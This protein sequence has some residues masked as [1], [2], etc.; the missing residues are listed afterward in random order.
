METYPWN[1]SMQVP[2][3][4]ISR[5]LV[6][7]PFMTWVTLTARELDAKRPRERAAVNFIFDI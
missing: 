4:W 7:P 3:V 5:S 1:R 6:P 2:S